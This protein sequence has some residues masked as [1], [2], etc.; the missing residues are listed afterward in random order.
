[1]LTNQKNSME[2]LSQIKPTKEELVFLQKE[3][4]SFI[5]E[6]NLKLKKIKV[7]ATIGGSFAKN[8][9]LRE[10]QEID[11]FVKF[12]YTQYKNQSEKLSAILA[13]Y[14]PHVTRMH[15]SRDY[16]QVKR[17]NITFEIVPVLDIKNAKQALNVTDISPLHTSYVK[18]HLTLKQA[19][20]VRLLKQFCKANNL[21]GAESYIQGFSGY[22]LE[23]LV[24]HYK[25]FINV[26]KQA[27]TGKEKVIIDPA[28]HYTTKSA[29]LQTLN[30]AKIYS[31][32][33]IVDPVQPERNIAAALSEEKFTLLK[34][35]AKAYLK[36]QNKEFFTLK[37]FV[38]DS[39]KGYTILKAIPLEG[40][41][42]VIG[43]KLLKVFLFLK[44][45]LK[46]EEFSLQRSGW[47][48]NRECYFYFKARE[49]K[50]SIYKKH[51]GPFLEDTEHMVRFK[52]K[53]KNYRIRKEKKRVIVWIPRRYAT[54]H[55]LLNALCKGS[56]VKT[57]VKA[58]T[59]L[60]RKL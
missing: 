52:K 40:N 7:K 50:L 44:T 55:A 8:T 29:L 10:T 45:Q 46:L 18:K 36:K 25:T 17:K 33:I 28:K 13:R 53:W 1:M 43:A 23:I 39:L 22:V 57:K 12:P 24:L 3:A 16:F 2:I 19:D 15:G 51:Y 27:S 35:C 9:L 58:I 31:P 49:K 59:L 32:L 38:L 30:V 56:Y 21:Y 11:I 20:D 48:W 42:D 4:S 5:K 6:L 41:R 14:L 37:P 47:H 60:H 34:K 26:L 54:M